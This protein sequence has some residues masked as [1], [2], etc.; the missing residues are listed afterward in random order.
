MNKD[1]NVTDFGATCDGVDDSG[2]SIRKALEAAVLAGP[3]ARLVFEPGIY[4]L[5]EQEE[6]FYHF[7]L[8]GVRG[9]TIEGNGAVLLNSPKHSILDMDLC[10]DITVRGLVFD[11][12]PL[13]FTQG[14]V[15]S[16]DPESGSFVLQIHE[17]YRLPPSNEWVQEHY[18]DDGGWF[19]GC[20]MD[21]ERPHRKW[22]V[23]DHLRIAGIDVFAEEERQFRIELIEDH[24]QWIAEF[25]VGERFTFPLRDNTREQ[26]TRFGIRNTQIGSVFNVQR[27]SNCL[28]EDFA[29]YSSRVAMF[30]GLGRNV[31]PITLH[32]HRLVFKPG[33]NRLITIWKDYVHAKENRVGPVIENCVFEGLMDDSINLGSNTAMAT[34][35]YSP[36][37][38]DLLTDHEL[39][40]KGSAFQVGDSVMVFDPTSGE[41]VDTASVVS[42]EGGNP[43][44]VCFDRPIPNVIKGSITPHK[45]ITSTHLY[46]LNAIGAGFAVR[47]CHFGLQRRH[48]VLLRCSDGVFEDN[49]VV[50]VG[51][52]AI[53]IKNEFGSW[54]EGPFPQNVTV[55]NNQ[56]RDCQGPAIEV[57]TKSCNDSC[58][59]VSDIN[60]CNNEISILADDGYGILIQ[61]AAKITVDST[62][63][64]ASDPHRGLNNNGIKVD[65]V[66]ELEIRTGRTGP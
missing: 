35:V 14:D 1:I 5:A 47:N 24:K 39:P 34:Q 30:F 9:L 66:T 64:T 36:S 3:G 56:I 10:E 38:M 32:N 63:I 57:S 16:S 27:C 49:T 2:P 8:T 53:A 42:V 58:R 12:D 43:A 19:W 7:T 48:G 60:I 33:T 6:S 62:T 55:R 13:P 65:N 51:G 46:N 11:H 61:N 59:L 50:E 23:A 17:G 4:R 15:I 44:R 37:E 40:L 54:Y 28:F 41:I 18:G 52:S 45:D 21:P 20:L 29:V 25:K 31:G 22:E 26:L